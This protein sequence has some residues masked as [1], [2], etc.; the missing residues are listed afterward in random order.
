MTAAVR[1][2]IPGF[3]LE[4]EA[5]DDGLLY[6]LPIRY[7]TTFRGVPLERPLP[8]KV[9]GGS[10]L[11]TK[12]YCRVNLTG[13]VHFVHRLIA[14]AFIP[15]PHGL[16]QVNHKNGIKDDNQPGNLEWVSNFENRRHSVH[17]GTQARGSRV[18]ARLTESDVHRIRAL[19]AQGISQRAVASAFGVVQQTISHIARRS[20]WTHV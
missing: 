7:K 13:S 4:Y 16:P 9:L 20:T 19:L 12:G 3:P 10:K 14:L 11:S 15:N 6:R 5:G 18:S 2:K 17:T 1:K 8:E